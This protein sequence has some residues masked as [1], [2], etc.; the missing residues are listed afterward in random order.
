[1][2]PLALILATWQS[3]SFTAP[4][5]SA[6]GNV[7]PVAAYHALQ[8][9]E[10]GY[11]VER[12]LYARPDVS[13]GRPVPHAPG[14]RDTVWLSASDDGKPRMLWLYSADSAGNWSP[15]SNPIVLAMN[16]L[17]DTFFV[18][19]TGSVDR[20]TEKAFVQSRPA[21]ASP[22]K[23]FAAWSRVPGDSTFTILPKWKDAL[24]VTTPVLSGREFQ[25]RDRVEACSISLLTEGRAYWC[26]ED[27]EHECP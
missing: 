26:A 13:A 5:D 22:G 10:V 15:P 3:V 20:F 18:D 1:M 16:V 23:Y 6:Y 24:N 19:L 12:V 8:L 21:L 14:I 2:I 27:R 4:A 17:R 25:W 11:R 7:V 9:D